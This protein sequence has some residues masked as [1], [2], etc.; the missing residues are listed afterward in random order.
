MRTI[1]IRELKNNTSQILREVIETGAEIV[2]THRGKPVARF[3]PVAN[4]HV[5]DERLSGIFTDVNH[6]ADEI[7]G[8]WPEGVDATTAVR[9]QRRE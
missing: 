7:G 1:G 2:I 5:N 4:I 8:Q 3:L 6:L 9:E